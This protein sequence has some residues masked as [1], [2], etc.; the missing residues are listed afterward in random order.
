MKITITL[1]CSDCQSTKVKKN[2]EKIS[3]RQNYLCKECERQFIGD[4][5]LCYKGCHSGLT[6]KILLM[7]VRGAGIRDM[8]E[9]EKINA[10][11]VLPV[12]VSS[13][14]LIQPQQQY[15]DCLEVDE[16]HELHAL[17]AP[18]PFLVFTCYLY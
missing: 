1:H 5:T 13:R 18:R 9:I 15:Y 8:A 10:K 2:G 11:K 3:K 7:P 6:Q 17:M 14:H 16:L 4:C 12:S